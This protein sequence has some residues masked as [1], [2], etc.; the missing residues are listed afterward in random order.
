MKTFWK[1]YTIILPKEKEY[2][3]DIQNKKINCVFIQNYNI[4]SVFA[5]TK[6]H[7][8]EIEIP[9]NRTSIINRPFPL[10]YIYFYTKK[11]T[12]ITIVETV[13]QNP[14]ASFIRQEV[15]KNTSIDTANT[16]IQNTP[17]EICQLDGFRPSVKGRMTH[18]AFRHRTEFIFDLGSYSA[19]NIY[20]LLRSNRGS[21]CQSTRRAYRNTMLVTSYRI[22]VFNE[23]TRYIRLAYFRFPFQ[24]TPPEIIIN[25]D[26]IK[27]HSLN[28]FRV[29][30][31]I[32]N[33]AF[34]YMSIISANASITLADR[35]VIPIR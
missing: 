5:G 17:L 20:V 21:A 18:P 6:P 22:F 29:F 19:P 10:E 13:T 8:Y 27:F 16:I 4:S 34:R 15:T 25:S 9:P 3:F 12:P 24:D 33:N 7:S 2:V 31:S 30:L 1:E 14:I 26:N 23:N 28:M 35:I 32:I 11:Q